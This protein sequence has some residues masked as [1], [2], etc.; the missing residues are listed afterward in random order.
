M[1]FYLSLSWHICIL[2]PTVWKHSGF[3]EVDLL[4]RCYVALAVYLQSLKYDHAITVR[5]SWCNV[6]W[7]N[8]KAVCTICSFSLTIFIS[9]MLAE[10]LANIFNLSDKVLFWSLTYCNSINKWSSPYTMAVHYFPEHNNS[11]QM[12]TWMAVSHLCVNVYH[13]FFNILCTFFYKNVTKNW[14]TQLIR[15]KAGNDV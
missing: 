3:E 12:K 13:I 10:M 7:K 15:I 11:W 5:S 14:A 1:C 9:L 6:H 2:W 4:S 8:C